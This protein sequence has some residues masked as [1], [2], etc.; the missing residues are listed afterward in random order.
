MIYHGWSGRLCGDPGKKNRSEVVH[1]AKH[2]QVFVVDFG[3]KAFALDH[4]I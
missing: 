1:Y 4:L 3:T 2:Q